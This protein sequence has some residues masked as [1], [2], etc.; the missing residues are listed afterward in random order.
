MRRSGSSLERWPPPLPGYDAIEW[1]AWIS[2]L[3][4]G[5]NLTRM[6]TLGTVDPPLALLNL[7]VL[8]VIAGVG[9]W[10]SVP[11]LTRRLMH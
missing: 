9:Y 4:H 8:A 7:V 3:W 10:W 5:V 2:P 1:L 11:R 6:L